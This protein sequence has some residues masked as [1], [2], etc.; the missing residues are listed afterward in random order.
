M[1]IIDFVGLLCCLVFLK[2]CVGQIQTPEFIKWQTLRYKNLPGEID[3]K[4]NLI[5][6]L[7]K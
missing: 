7:R 6:Q 5:N 3:N 4:K 1:K 2:I